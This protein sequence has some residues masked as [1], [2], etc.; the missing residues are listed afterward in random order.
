MYNI[1]YTY[2]ERKYVL[3]SGTLCVQS[4]EGKK[5]L[6]VPQSQKLPSLILA[7]SNTC[8]VQ[9]CKDVYI[10]QCIMYL[11][12]AHCV[13]NELRSKKTLIVPQSQKLPCLIH[14]MS[15]TC[16]VQICKDVYIY[17]TVYTYKYYVLISGTL[18]VQSVEGQE[19]ADCTTI[20]KIN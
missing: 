2:V 9:I 18:C 17:T 1:V 8:Y 12:W 19:D 16:N 14:V 3:I 7:M 10:L 11:Y 20:P 5:T 4:V 15:Y 6:I 13:F